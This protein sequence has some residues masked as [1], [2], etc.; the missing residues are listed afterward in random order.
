[1]AS[2]QKD[3]RDRSNSESKRKKQED[4]RLR[5]EEEEREEERQRKKAEEPLD[6]MAQKGYYD[7]LFK[8]MEDRKAKV[9]AMD[10]E[11]EAEQREQAELEAKIQGMQGWLKKHDPIIEKKKKDLAKMDRKLKGLQESADDPEALAR[12]MDEPDS[13]SDPPKPKKAASA[14]EAAERLSKAHNMREQYRSRVLQGVAPMQFGLSTTPRGHGLEAVETCNLTA[15]GKEGNEVPVRCYSPAGKPFNAAPAPPAIVFFHGGGYVVG[16]LE[17]HDW[18][19]RSLAALAGSTVVSVDYR[20][21]PEHKYPAAINDAYAA[22][23]WV[24]QGGLGA[25][26]RRIAVAGDCAGGGMAAACCL[27]AKDDPEGPKIA[28]QLLAYPWLD[29]RPHAPSM[30][31]EFSD[32]RHGLSG[33]EC[34]FYREAYAPEGADPTGGGAWTEA[35]DASPILAQSLVGLPRAFIAYPV[36]SM[37]ADEA[38]SFVER[39]RRDVGPEAVHTMRVEGPQHHFA[40]MASEPQ[41]QHVVFAAATFASAMLWAPE[42]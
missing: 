20:R 9:R 7:Q 40:V 42:C 26:P 27:R 39:L 13:P 6:V 8:E 12:I 31:H 34:R 28:L 3:K 2:A 15:T 17:T 5:R 37:L 30:T 25:Y 11:I 18:L 1:M 14:L 35:L 32:G 38:V 29:L 41:T 33:D 16:D 10:E 19:C 23:L 4:A 21:A 24:A 22:L 36:H